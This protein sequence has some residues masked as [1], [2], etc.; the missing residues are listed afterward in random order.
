MPLLEVQNLQ[1]QFQTPEQTV[2]AVS[3]LSFTLDRNETVGLVGESGSG[4]SATALALMG[5]PPAKITG[6]S[7]RF[8]GEELV[9]KP[10][11]FLQKLRG[12]KM[13]MIFQDP[14]SSLDP[15]MSIGAQ[16]IEAIRIHLPLKGKAAYAYALEL[17]K[18]VHMPTPEQKMR[19]F[20]HELSGGQRQRVLIAMAFACKPLLLIA[21]EPTTALDVTVQAQ[22]LDRTA[23]L[24]RQHSSGLLLITH[25][26]GVVAETCHR[27]LVMYAGQL[28]EAGTTEQIFRNPLHPYTQGLLAATIPLEKPEAR[29]QPLPTI[30]GQPPS[31]TQKF[32]GCPFFPRCRA[33]IPNLCD[34]EKVPLYSLPSGRQVRC[35]LYADQRSGTS[36]DVSSV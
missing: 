35:L 25:D 5:L 26:L 27:T 23:V 2:Y 13:A 11:E 20:P 9:G 8:D 30:P 15:T 32:T 14:F 24:Q 7:I 1:V 4:K 17:L 3:D 19:Q 28:M 22:I 16:L 12:Q 18:N 33:R 29:R 36:S 10:A 34:K 6:G 21:D 31:L